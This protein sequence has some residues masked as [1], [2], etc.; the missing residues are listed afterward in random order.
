MTGFV[1]V[2]V[3]RL[4]GVFLVLRPEAAVREEAAVRVG[5][6]MIVMTI[7]RC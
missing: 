4:E 5:K 3:Q 6:M 7:A 2:V 1:S